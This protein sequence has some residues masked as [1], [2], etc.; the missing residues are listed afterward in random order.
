MILRPS[1]NGRCV[2]DVASLVKHRSAE[3]RRNDM[4]SV[5]PASSFPEIT[6]S[7]RPSKLRFED[8]DRAILSNSSKCCRHPTRISRRRDSTPR[9]RGPIRSFDRHSAEPELRA[10]AKAQRPRPSMDHA[11]SAG[12]H[13]RVEL[14]GV[15]GITGPPAVA[16][17]RV[18]QMRNTHRSNRCA[19]RR[20]PRESESNFHRASGRPCVGS[21]DRCSHPSDSKIARSPAPCGCRLNDALGRS[22]GWDRS[23]ARFRRNGTR[24]TP[25]ALQWEPSSHRSSPASMAARFIKARWSSGA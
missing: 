25:P 7:K 23:R 15:V 19:D 24:T 11:S 10:P 8:A 6:G 20:Q 3:E 21:D 2:G 4:R 9:H 13:R 16:N 14:G 18:C 17:A 22:S 1:N 12:A 5:S